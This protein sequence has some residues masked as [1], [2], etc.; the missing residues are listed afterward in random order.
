MN[1]NNTCDGASKIS[2]FNSEK[3]ICLDTSI[4]SVAIGTANSYTMKYSGWFNSQ[5]KIFL[6]MEKKVMILGLLIYIQ[7]IN[8]PKNKS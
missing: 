3:K 5:W 6:L 7:M 8:V 4:E 1:T 2:L